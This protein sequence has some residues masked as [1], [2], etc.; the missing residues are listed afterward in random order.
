MI[1]SSSRHEVHFVQKLAFQVRMILTIRNLQKQDI[2]KYRCA[3]K[4]SLGE[5]DSSIRL[6]GKFR[7]SILRNKGRKDTISNECEII[8]RVETVAFLHVMYTIFHNLSI[9]NSAL[10][11]LYSGAT[12]SIPRPSDESTFLQRAA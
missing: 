4:N 6:Y 12:S 7:I 11:C 5:V 10:W 3:A 2:G 1:I 8:A 9:V